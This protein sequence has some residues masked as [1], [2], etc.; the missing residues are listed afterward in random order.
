[1]FHLIKCVVSQL[2]HG[3]DLL[4]DNQ[5]RHHLLPDPGIVIDHCLLSD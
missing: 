2:F 4:G 3:N 5:I 1:M